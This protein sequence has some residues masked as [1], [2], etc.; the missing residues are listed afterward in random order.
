MEGDRL[1]RARIRM[2]SEKPRS[3][4]TLASRAY[5]TPIRLWS[6]LDTIPPD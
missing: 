2:A 6:T 5:M 1:L 3:S 4:I